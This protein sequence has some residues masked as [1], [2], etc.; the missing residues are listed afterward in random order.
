MKN[1]LKKITFGV[2][3]LAACEEDDGNDEGGMQAEDSGDTGEEG[4][5]SVRPVAM[6]RG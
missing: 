6:E 3:L 4:S 2:L 5:G 1:T